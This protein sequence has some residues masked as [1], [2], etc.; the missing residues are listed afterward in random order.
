[1]VSCCRREARGQKA[2]LAGCQEGEGPLCP[3]RAHSTVHTAAPPPQPSTAPSLKG[4]TERSSWGHTCG[5]GRKRQ[6]SS[7]RSSER[8]QIA[9][10]ALVERINWAIHTTEYTQL[11]ARARQRDPR[12]GWEQ[13][14]TSGAEKKSQGSQCRSQAQKD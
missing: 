10:G 12:A 7:V 6:H 2:K 11:L 8:L 4:P 13:P 14:P 3:L 1:M 9:R 5:R